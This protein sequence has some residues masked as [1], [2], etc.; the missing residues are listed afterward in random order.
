MATAAE[1]AEPRIAAMIALASETGGLAFHNAN[2]VSASIRRAIQD[3][4][5]SYI[6]GFYPPE[7]AWDG[8]YH[9]IG[10]QVKRSGAQVRGHKGYFADPEGMTSRLIVPRPSGSLPPARSKARPLASK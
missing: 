8:E 7:E 10:I 1:E 3:A 5:V 4:S 2:G 9:E 6:L